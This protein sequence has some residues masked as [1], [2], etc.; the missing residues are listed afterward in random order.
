METEINEGYLRAIIAVLKDKGV[1]KFKCQ[2]FEVDFLF[3]MSAEEEEDDGPVSQSNI[4]FSAE[5]AHE[6][7]G[8]DGMYKRAFRGVMPTL[9]VV[10][11]AEVADD[12]ALAFVNP[13]GN[14]NA[15]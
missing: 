13:E 12:P 6:D 2:L 14:G 10:R 8:V 4:G 15:E 1:S 3:E 11:A 7:D 9:A 5:T